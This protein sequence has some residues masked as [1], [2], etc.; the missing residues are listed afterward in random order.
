MGSSIPAAAGDFGFALQAAKIGKGGTFT[1]G[2][3]EW[4]RAE[5][6]SVRMDLIQDDQVLPPEVS[7][8]ISPRGA[9]KDGEFGAGQVDMLP[10]LEHAMGILL[11]GLMGAVSSVTGVNADGDVLATAY[12]HIFKFDTSPYKIPWMVARRLVP[13]SGTGIQGDNF[14]DCKLT[15]LRLTV[16]GRGKASVRAT[17]VGRDVEQEENPTWT[18]DYGYEDATS[19]PAPLNGF[20][21]I[22]GTEYPVT[23][24]VV[25]VDN[26]VTTPAQERIIGSPNPDDFVPLYRVATIRFVYK[27]TDNTLY[28]LLRNGGTGLTW[29]E[30]PEIFTTV[31]ANRALEISVPAP[32]KISGTE[33]YDL[34]L[35]VNAMTI[36]IDGPIELAGAQIL[37]QAFTA[38]ALVPAT[39]DYLNFVLVNKHPSYAFSYTI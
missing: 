34:R 20:V 21:K 12:T 7:P 31:G 2:D 37:Q 32:L 5:A 18:W 27:W 1:V 30:L 3:Y 39:G 17:F 23:A 6:N 35:R 14:F 15:N 22:E 26:G 24:A 19:T 9:F 36:G 28:K 4:Y 33:P 10:R 11:F 29:E 16:P 38:T 25:E 8:I 13:G